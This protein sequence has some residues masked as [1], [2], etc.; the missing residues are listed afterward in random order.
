MSTSCFDL[1]GSTAEGGHKIQTD[2]LLSL[3]TFS[4]RPLSGMGYLSPSKQTDFNR[5]VWCCSFVSVKRSYVHDST[6]A[7]RQRKIRLE[8]VSSL[9]IFIGTTLA[10]GAFL[11]QS[12]HIWTLLCWRDIQKLHFSCC[13]VGRSVSSLGKPCLLFCGCLGWDQEK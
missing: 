11:H 3:L 4:L 9:H 1:Q 10:G 2:V 8:V 13:I 7:L 5:V 12:N 6:A